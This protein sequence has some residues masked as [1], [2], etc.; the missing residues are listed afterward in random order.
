M[1]VTDGRIVH[2]VL[3]IADNRGRVEIP[4]TGRDQGLMH[5]QCDGAC[6]ADLAEV[7]ALPVWGRSSI[8]ARTHRLF[9]QALRA[10]EVRQVLNVLRQCFHN[11][12]ADAGRSRIR[13]I[14]AGCARRCSRNRDPD[15]SGSSRAASSKRVGQYKANY[16]CSGN[17]Q[18]D[19]GAV[20]PRDTQERAGQ[21]LVDEEFAGDQDSTRNHWRNSFQS[22]G[23]RNAER[24]TETDPA[25]RAKIL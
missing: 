14:C 4:A 3:Q 18:G 13:V 15:D 16:V 21:S 1:V 17:H 9:D 25:Y 10:A 11:S 8:A 6:T 19:P 2:H 5:V 22:T 23:V 7:D 24:F 12:P 20:S